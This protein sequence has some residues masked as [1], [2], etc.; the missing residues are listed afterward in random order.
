MTPES[1]HDWTVH[2]INIH[3]IFFERFC[4]KVID[5]NALWEL[6]AINYP[7]EFPPARGPIRGRESTLDIRACRELDGGILTLLIEC[8]KNNPEFVDW[9]FFPRYFTS[10][11]NKLW[12]PQIENIQDQNSSAQWRPQSNF[13]VITA[14]SET[15]VCDAARETR[16]SYTSHKK[17]D[18]TRTSNASIED[19]AYQVTI[20]TQTIVA[21][22]QQFS[23]V[24]SVGAPERSLPW[25][26]QVFLPT[27]V[28]SAR[29]FTCDFNP[30][31]IDKLTGEIAYEKAGITEVPSLF[32][33][34]PVPRHLQGIPED[35]GRV[36]S[37]DSIELFMRRH[38]LI[39]QSAKLEEVL[40]L[41]AGLA[42]HFV[43]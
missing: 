12:F 37:T 32:F 20:A 8:K 16:G 5:K 23:H 3:G 30:A 17:G 31:D 39:V 40:Y 6:K 4:Q 35:L 26:K 11:Q 19:A 9:I 25:K 18:R 34:Y 7:V 22:E 38:I 42:R 15:L 14:S 41:Y 33:E 27:V 2:S 21:E 43:T 28:T 13:K 10:N 36:A 29:I 24:L 1:E